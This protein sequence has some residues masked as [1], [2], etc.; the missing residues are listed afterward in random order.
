MLEKSVRKGIKRLLKSARRYAKM[1]DQLFGPYVSDR[2]AFRPF[3]F[4]NE[5]SY[6]TARQMMSVDLREAKR[7]ADEM[8]IDIDHEIN[9]IRQI[10]FKKAIKQNLKKA[11]HAGTLP[12]ASTCLAKVKRLA[13]QSGIDINHEINKI[14]KQTSFKKAIKQNLM[15]TRLFCMDC[16][17]EFLKLLKK[18]IGR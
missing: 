16:R 13:R 10:S 11:R 7:L 14:K 17:E 6:T 3:L 8:G 15:E 18:F 4:S 12:Y 1:G 9:K 2:R 5:F